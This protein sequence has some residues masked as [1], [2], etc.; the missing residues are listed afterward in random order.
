MWMNPFLQLGIYK[1][2]KQIKPK[3]QYLSKAEVLEDKE[4]I[5]MAHHL[6]NSFPVCF[7]SKDHGQN[8]S[9]IKASGQISKVRCC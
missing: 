1:S 2:P 5:T 3:E 9:K 6:Y 8:L 4:E 7:G